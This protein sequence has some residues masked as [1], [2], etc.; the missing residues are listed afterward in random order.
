MRSPPRRAWATAAGRGHPASRR[1]ALR[2][3]V[4]P[5]GD[6]RS[7]PGLGLPYQPGKPVVRRTCRVAVDGRRRGD[8]AQSFAGSRRPR[9]GTT[10][11]DAARLLSCKRRRPPGSTPAAHIGATPASDRSHRARPPDRR[12]RGGRRPSGPGRAS[13]TGPRSGRGARI[14]A[15][16]IIGRDAFIDEGVVDRRPGQDPERRARL[17]RRDRRGRRLHRAQRDPHQRPLPARDHRRRRARPGRRLG[18][19]PDPPAARLLDR[20]RARSSWPA[21]TSAGSRRS[22]PAPSSPATSPT[23]RSSPATRP[24]ASAGSAPAASAWPTRPA[25]PSPRDRAGAAA[26]PG[27]RRRATTSTATA[28]SP[29]HHGGHRVI[30]ISKPDIGPAEEEAVLEVLRSGMLAMGRRT[31]EFEEAWA[32]YCGVRHA[33]FMANGTVAQ[34]ARPAR[35][36]HRPGRRGHHGQL[37]LQRDGQRDPAGRRDARSS[38]TSARTTS[39]WTRTWSRRRSR[40]GRRRSCRSTCTASW[41]T[42]TRSSRSRERHGLAIVEDAAQAHGAAYRG[43]RAGQFG[44]AMFSLYATK[45]LMTGEGGF[46]TT[47]DDGAGRPAPP[48]PQP[49][50]AR[51]LP[52]RGAG[53][54]L[55]ADRPRGG[56]RA[57]PA[58]APRRAH[59]AAPAQRRPPHARACAATS[60][61]SVPEGRE[62][63]WHQYTMRFP[64][65]RQRGHRRADRARHR[66]AHLLPGPDPPAGLPAGVRAR[67]GRPRPARSRTGS[68]DEVLS[69]PVRPEPHRRRA[70]GRRSPPSARS[71]RRSS[72]P[73]RRRGRRR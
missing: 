60:T 21:A 61:P 11:P 68:S 57:R 33:V 69:I 72:R 67:R 10:A 36:G 15:E 20:R 40:P 47:D 7:T 24:A 39:A 13:G 46:A 59:R 55:Q 49:R 53:H 23:T 52:P 30:P 28:A 37:Q 26:L 48:V 66:D 35:A 16:C 38:W 62:H 43:R 32:A 2:E 4:D 44:P 27:V 56:H 71:R 14:G 54:E 42:W 8:D 5:G 73:R 25:R 58:G 29:L 41:P 12:P 45:N 65:E 18:R 22:A 34:E 1:R 70:R 31:A 63:V 64:G 19:Q 3:G 50:D 17:P 51:P 6:S 9:F